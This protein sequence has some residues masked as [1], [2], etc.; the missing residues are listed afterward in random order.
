MKTLKA[1]F[2]TLIGP[3]LPWESSPLKPSVALQRGGGP[4]DGGISLRRN[5][6]RPLQ[7]TDQQKLQILE[8]R[9]TQQARMQSL[10]ENFRQGDMTPRIRCVHSAMNCV[11]ATI[12]PCRKSSPKEQFAKLVELR[13]GTT[14]HQ[15]GQLDRVVVGADGYQRGNRGQPRSRLMQQGYP[16]WQPFTPTITLPCIRLGCRWRVNLPASDSFPKP[17]VRVHP[18]KNGLTDAGRT[19]PSPVLNLRHC[20]LCYHELLLPTIPENAL[21]GFSGAVQSRRPRSNH[22]DSGTDND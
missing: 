2:L 11:T 17:V 22:R 5:D 1:L 16:P 14:C 12:R 15:P 18:C 8:L 20:L 6:V 19:N 4:Q 7:L 13:A 9:Q 3:Y 21:L 10:R